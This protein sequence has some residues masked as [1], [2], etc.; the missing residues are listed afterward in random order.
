[1]ENVDSEGTFDALIQRYFLLKTAVVAWIYHVFSKTSKVSNRFLKV[2]RVFQLLFNFGQLEVDNLSLIEISHLLN[3]GFM[4]DSRSS[5]SIE[6]VSNDSRETQW[7]VPVEASILH[8]LAE[9][10]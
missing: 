4:I 8:E 10:P 2:M 3:K 9:P 6:L 1:M 7:L 5:R